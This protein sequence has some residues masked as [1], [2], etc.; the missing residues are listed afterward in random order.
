[1]SLILE[2]MLPVFVCSRAIHVHR[3]YGIGNAGVGQSGVEQRGR[4]YVLRSPA[5]YPR[6]YLVLISSTMVSRSNPGT[7]SGAKGCDDNLF[8][9]F[10]MASGVA[11]IVTS[12]QYFG[13]GV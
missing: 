10:E 1:M 2:Q 8:R 5:I 6:K 12:R 9:L 4:F 11:G 7:T 13:R 3:R